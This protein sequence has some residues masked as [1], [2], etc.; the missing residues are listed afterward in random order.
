MPKL[1]EVVIEY[2]DGHLLSGTVVPTGPNVR[3]D[4]AK[5]ICLIEPLN[6]SICPICQIN[7]ADTKEHVPPGAFGGKP[8]TWTCG[9][10]N[11]ML[12]SRTEAAMQD[13]FDSAARVHYTAEGAARPFGHTRAI[14]LRTSDG[15]LIAMPERGSDPGPEFDAKMRQGG[16]IHSHWHLPRS[17][18][19]RNGMLKNAYLAA[20]LH[21]GQVPD[22]QS[23]TEI[24]AELQAVAQ[25]ASRRVTVAGPHAAKLRFYR[26]GAPPTV[27]LAL[28]HGNGLNDGD[29]PEHLIALAGTV[30]VDWPFPE[31]NPCAIAQ[32]RERSDS[33]QVDAE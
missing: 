32:A 7:A 22:V 28:L 23:A 12:G 5:G 27:S 30:L 10:C 2:G 8:M 17:A 33:R 25:A 4:T 13:W 16:R 1:S 9:R 21:I 18:E 24:R 14:L 29:R 19:I 3:R 31:I 6:F 15:A 20:C 26:T 11:N